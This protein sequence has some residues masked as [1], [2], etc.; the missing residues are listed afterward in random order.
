M[1]LNSDQICAAIE[2][3]EIEISPFEPKFLKPASYVLRLGSQ[4]RSWIKQDVPVDL[5]TDDCSKNALTMPQ[6]FESVNIVQ[7]ELHLITSLEKIRIPEGFIGLLATTSHL[8]RAG[9][10]VTNDS[11]V[12]SPGFGS[13]GMLNLTFEVV[14]RNPNSVTLRKGL[15]VCHLLIAELKANKESR[16]LHRS[17]YETCGEHISGPAIFQ[18]LKSIGM[19]QVDHPA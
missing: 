6:Q 16:P 19:S 11:S 12:V 14:S 18:E 1:F 5:M 9:I 2:S 7:G 4:I 10:S 15:P 8:A 3:S 13:Q 17:V